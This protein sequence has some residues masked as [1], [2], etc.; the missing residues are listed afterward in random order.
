MILEVKCL[1]HQAGY[2][3][4]KVKLEYLILKYQ[5]QVWIELLLERIVSGVEYRY[6]KQLH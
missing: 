5:H 3:L 6:L 4:E 1:V 2:N